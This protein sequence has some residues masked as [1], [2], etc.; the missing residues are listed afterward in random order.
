MTRNITETRDEA[1][2]SNYYKQGA[3]P[4]EPSLFAQHVKN[5]YLEPGQ[6]LLELGCG[7]GRDAQFLANQGLKV[8]A[9]DQC[10]SEINVLEAQNKENDNIHFET[11]DFTELPDSESPY[12]AIYS[13]FTLHSVSSEGQKRALGWSAR[14][15]VPGGLLCIET[16]GQKNELFQRGDPVEGEQ[17][18]YVYEDHYRR[19]V[20]FEDFVRQIAATGFKL[21]EAS[22]E[23]G[24]APYKDTDYHF[25]R[26]VAKKDS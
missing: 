7:N 23:T 6:S 15:L 17:D 8:T 3:A 4:E 10:A 9:V 19:F 16:R 13:R 12:N 25:I 20:K 1:Y 11:A 5:Q 21:L 2:W 14:N 18:A 24:Y 26:I 22:E